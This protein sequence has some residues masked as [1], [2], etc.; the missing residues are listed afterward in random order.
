MSE[1]D[2]MDECCLRVCGKARAQLVFITA[3]DHQSGN[4]VARLL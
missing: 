4:D 3:P 2:A 1:V